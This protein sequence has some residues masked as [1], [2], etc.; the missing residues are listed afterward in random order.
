MEEINPPP[1]L[2]PGQKKKNQ[3][4]F[5]SRVLSQSNLYIMVSIKYSVI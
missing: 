3:C 5:A 1:P 2:A 4:L